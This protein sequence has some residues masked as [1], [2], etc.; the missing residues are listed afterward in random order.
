MVLNTACL[1]MEPNDPDFLRVTHRT[2]EYINEQKDYDVLSSTRFFGPMVF[3]LV[4]YQKLDNIIAYFINSANLSGCV[5]LIKLYFI[6][7]ENEAK[8]KSMVNENTSELELI[9]VKFF[10]LNT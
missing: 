6:V 8:D 7:H 3:Y 9:Q 5:D 10:L 2:Y 4:W 1:K